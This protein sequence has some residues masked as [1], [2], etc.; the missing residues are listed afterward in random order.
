MLNQLYFNYKTIW[1]EKNSTKA[2]GLDGFK[3][4]MICHVKCCIKLEEYKSEEI[5]VEFEENIPS[6][7]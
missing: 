2:S 3:L 1:I 5:S 6:K 4:G 7:E